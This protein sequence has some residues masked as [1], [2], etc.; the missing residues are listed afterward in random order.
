VLGAACA[1]A[2]PEVHRVFTD[3]LFPRQAEVADFAGWAAA[4]TAPESGRRRGAAPSRA[5]GGA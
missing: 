3:K 4:L 5:P 2:D 1:D